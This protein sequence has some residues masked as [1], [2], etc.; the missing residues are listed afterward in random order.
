MVTVVAVGLHDVAV[1]DEL[2]VLVEGMAA[3]RMCHVVWCEVVRVLVVY[4]VVGEWAGSPLQARLDEHC[5][6]AV[7]SS[8]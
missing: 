5:S 6:S 1:V 2:A 4:R 3:L 7:Q 8:A